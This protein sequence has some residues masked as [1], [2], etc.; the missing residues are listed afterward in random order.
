MRTFGF[1]LCAVI[2]MAMCMG[3]SSLANAADVWRAPLQPV[4]EGDDAG[5]N[6]TIVFARQNPADEV[7]KP[8]QLVVVASGLQPNTPYLVKLPD[9][10][11]VV[12]TNEAGILT[13][14]DS[15]IVPLVIVLSV[16]IIGPEGK[17]LVAST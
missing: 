14:H 11:E 10:L 2:V 12:T 6:V 16:E 13:L 1:G 3:M 9:Y 4:N 7:P 17:R 15:L 5:G 8:D